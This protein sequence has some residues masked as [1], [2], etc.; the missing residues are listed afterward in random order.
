MGD[1]R[2]EGGED[3]IVGGLQYGLGSISQP[4]PLAAVRMYL[5]AIGFERD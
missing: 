1:E 2:W 5:P 4:L 3:D